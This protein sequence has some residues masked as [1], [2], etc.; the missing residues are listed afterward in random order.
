MFESD[1]I[2]GSELKN[3]AGTEKDV[4]CI[5]SPQYNEGFFTTQRI[6]SD[7]VSSVWK[8]LYVFI[9]GILGSVERAIV[10]YTDSN[11][12]SYPTKEVTIAW[13]NATQFAVTDPIVHEML[14]VGEEVF[15]VEGYGQGRLAHITEISES[16]TVTTVTID[17][18]YGTAA[19][20]SKVRFS[21]MKKKDSLTSGR[22]NDNLI[23]STFDSKSQWIQAKVELRGFEP[24]V[25]M[26]EL[27]NTVNKSAQ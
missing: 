23:R 21:N 5:L 24:S 3:N 17:E 7:N 16:L 4:L 15:F 22:E 11:K 14:E 18:S 6:Y 12:E 27:T 19:G 9:Q 26:L 2:F 13:A 20:A 1:I 8:T 25:P 10:K